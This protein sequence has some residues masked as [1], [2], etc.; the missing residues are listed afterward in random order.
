MTR[1]NWIHM[2]V[3][4]RI[5]NYATPDHLQ[6]D[7]LAELVVLKQVLASEEGAR[8]EVDRLNRLSPPAKKRYYYQSVKFFP[9]D[10]IDQSDIGP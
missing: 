9:E 8:Q 5:D 2:F 7:D 3:V 10:R 1:D 6:P 4:F